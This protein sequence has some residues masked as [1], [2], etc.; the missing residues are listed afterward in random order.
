MPQ[1]VLYEGIGRADYYDNQYD[2]ECPEEYV[3]PFLVQQSKREQ[4]LYIGM[5]AV[6]MMVVVQ[7]PG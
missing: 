5:A 6:H 1:I 2:T 3:H 4:A 7:K